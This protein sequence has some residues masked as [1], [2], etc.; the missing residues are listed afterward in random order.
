MM[1]KKHVPEKMFGIVREEVLGK[2]CIHAGLGWPPRQRAANLDALV[3]YGRSPLFGSQGQGCTSCSTDPFSTGHLCIAPLAW[4][5]I[6]GSNNSKSGVPELLVALQAFY[7][8]PLILF[9]VVKYQKRIRNVF[10]TCASHVPPSSIQVS[11]LLIW[12]WFPA[13]LIQFNSLNLTL[14]HFTKV[15]SPHRT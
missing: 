8:C 6:T 12:V 4:R 5:Q 13:S 3:W 9:L 10:E 2:Y 15:N 14:L 7:D 11:F 1:L